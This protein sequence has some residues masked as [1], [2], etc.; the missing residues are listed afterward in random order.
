MVLAPVHLLV[1]A[2]QSEPSWPQGLHMPTLLHTVL[3]AV[4]TPLP[5]LPT[6]QD[7]PRPPHS[8][9]AP[10]LQMPLPSPTQEPPGAR[11]IP[12]TQQPPPLQLVPSQQGMPA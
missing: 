7:E 10:L 11:Q 3:G 9:H 1:P 4:H 8:P 5:V 12:E 2:Q 6:Q